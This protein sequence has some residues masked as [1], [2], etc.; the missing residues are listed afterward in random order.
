VLVLAPG[1]TKTDFFR[2]ADG[3]DF[4][5]VGL[6]KRSPEP[7]VRAALD[8]LGRK[9][10]VI[11]G[12]MNRI[13]DALGKYVLSRTTTARVLGRMFGR[14]LTAPSVNPGGADAGE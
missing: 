7:V 3:I 1:P 14:A 12:V 5:K 8:G 10:I 4:A 11:P 9:A 2:G 13:Y 6:T